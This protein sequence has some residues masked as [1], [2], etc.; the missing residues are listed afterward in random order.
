MSKPSLLDRNEASEYLGIPVS[1]MNR[2][3]VDGVG[4]AFLKLGARV[5]YDLRELDHWLESR[6][7]QSTNGAR[8]HGRGQKRA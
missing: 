7:R 2:W 8:S 6:C 1:T 3:R 5:R 4:P